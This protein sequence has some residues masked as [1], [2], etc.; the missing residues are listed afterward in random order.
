MAVRVLDRNGNIKTITTTVV[1]GETDPI[2]IADKPDY[3][4]ILSASATYSVLGHT[5]TFA[6]LTGKPTTIA[7]YGIT[8]YNSLWDTRLALKTTTNLAEG[9]NLYFTD[10]R[11]IAAPLT[12][13]VSGA[14]TI[15]AADTILQAIQKLNGNIVPVPIDTDGT[16]TANSDLVVASQKATKTY[17]DTK[18]TLA[19]VNAQNLSAFASTTSAQMAS[20]VSDETGSGSLVFATSPTLVTP[21]LGTP[22]SGNLSNCT[23]PLL[24]E[25]ILAYQA[26]GSTLIAQ[27]VNGGLGEAMYSTSI[28]TDNRVL[29]MGVWLPVA[30]TI[31]GVKWK[32]VTQGNYT[33]DNYNGVGLYSYSGGT[34]TLVASS[35]DDGNIWKATSGTISSKA[36]SSPYVAARGLYFVAHLYCSSAQVTAPVTAMILSTTGVNTITDFTNSAKLNGFQTGQTALPASVAMNSITAYFQEV[37]TGLY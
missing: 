13:Y 26:L 21:A 9:T 35:T 3:L 29:Y 25:K 15:T 8:D 11:A 36:F 10:A 28:F 14:G 4:T 2:W 16:L 31:T 32:Q 18:T 33:A 7:G 5:H 34:L 1:T 12:G 30:Q 27:N 23:F 17:A 20:V 24:D 6:S 37:W 22:S 19:T